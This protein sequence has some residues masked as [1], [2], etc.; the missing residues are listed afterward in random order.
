MKKVLLAL[1]LLAAT[2]MNASAKIWRVNNN[3]G[4]VADFSNLQSA[5]NAAQSGDT[6]QVES[7]GGTYSIQLTKKLVVIGPGYFLNENPQ[8]QINTTG[9]TLYSA[10]FKP[11][12]SGSV[13]QGFTIYFTTV[14]ESGVTLQRNRLTS[15][16]EFATTQS[17]SNDTLRQNYLGASISGGTANTT[18]TGLLVYNNL[19]AASPIN[20]NTSWINNFNGYFINNSLTGSYYYNFICVNFVIQNNI[21][22]GVANNA[23]TLSNTWFNNVF[24]TAPFAA[25]NGNVVNANF[26]DIFVGWNSATGFS[27]DGRY[28]LKPVSVAKNAGTI[29]GMVVDC[30]A[31]GGPAPYVLSGM[32]PVPSV[33]QLT[34]PTQIP[35]GTPTMNL[36][37]SAASH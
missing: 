2:A 30:G 25:G 22:Y 34:A 29:N 27:S 6:L 37:I 10:E 32:P 12:S 15:G 31:F 7:S 23:Y 36:T 11:G 4:A 8:T 26:D 33:Y 14:N 16:L 18:C 19:I 35:S 20:I 24:G 9:A 17:I 3:A 13:V 28:K 21:I 5:H 1:T